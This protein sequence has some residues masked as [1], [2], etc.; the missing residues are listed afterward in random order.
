VTPADKCYV[1]RQV[2]AGVGYITLDRPRLNIITTAMARQI[3]E[4]VQYHD[5]DNDVRLIA[6]TATGDSAFAAGSDIGEHSPGSIDDHATAIVEMVQ[7]IVEA[8]GKPRVAV[9]N[10]ICAGGG[11]ELALACDVVLS[12]DR[13]RFAI[14]EIKLGVMGVLSA[15]LA[16]RRAGASTGLGLAMQGDWIDAQQAL[17]IG[18]IDHVFSAGKFDQSVAEYLM[19]LAAKSGPALAIGRKIFWS[20]LAA[21]SPREALDQILRDSIDEAAATQDYAEGI[22]AF[23]EHRAPRWSHR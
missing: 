3:A 19:Q 22:S 18:L 5:N 14:P 7:A 2:A 20:A 4:Y 21:A 13:S 9:V 1:K 23:L 17:G 16:A 12:S 11:C 15:Y 6:V 8:Q 10:G